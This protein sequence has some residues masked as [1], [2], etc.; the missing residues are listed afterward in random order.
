MVVIRMARAGRSKRPYYSIVAADSRF[1]RDG[2]FLQK[3]GRYNPRD[4]TGETLAGVDVPGILAWLG[5][6]AK[7]SDTVRTLLANNGV[8]L[9]QKPADSG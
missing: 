3:L 7:L 2:R 5:K 4:A 1:P 9:E 8:A 6:G